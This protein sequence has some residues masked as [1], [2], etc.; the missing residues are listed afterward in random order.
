MQ[1][2]IDGKGDHILAARFLLRF[3]GERN[4]WVHV[5]LSAATRRGDDHRP[6][7]S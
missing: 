3:I 7:G 6:Q 2:A 5:D 1:C 4:P